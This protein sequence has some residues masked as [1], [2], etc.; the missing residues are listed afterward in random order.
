[1]YIAK[2]YTQY[3]GIKFIFEAANKIAGLIL[4]YNVSI[5]CQGLTKRLSLRV[6]FYTISQLYRRNSSVISCEIRSNLNITLSI[7]CYLKFH[8]E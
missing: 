3:N 1:M 4:F 6:L 8:L 7:K 5:E 2:I